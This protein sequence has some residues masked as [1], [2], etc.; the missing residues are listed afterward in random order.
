LDGSI[1]QVLGFP[2]SGLR[3][4]QCA[5]VR[6]VSDRD[7]ERLRYL[8]ALGIRPGVAIRVLEVLPFDG[9]ALRRPLRALAKEPAA[10]YASAS[11]MAKALADAQAASTRA[12]PAIRSSPRTGA[13]SSCRTLLA[14][15][16]GWW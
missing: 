8:E 9:S 10:R 2:L 5:E 11:D 13:R 6:R 4:G 14:R 1:P 15:T 12:M 7:A 3:P 16:H